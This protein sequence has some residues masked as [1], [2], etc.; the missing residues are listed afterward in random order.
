ME[1]AAAGGSSKNAEVKQLLEQVASFRAQLKFAPFQSAVKMKA[2][3]T[4][5]QRT[6]SAAM[7]PGELHQAM[8]AH[9][10]VA[11][12]TQMMQFMGGDASMMRYGMMGMMDGMNGHAR[13]RSEA[14]THRRKSCPI[15]AY[16]RG[17]DHEVA[18]SGVR[19]STGS[20]RF[21][22]SAAA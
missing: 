15:R 9:I 8:M 7:I 17:G 18:L 12:M 6:K 3:L 20:G 4:D 10:T 22:S 21:S 14:M 16:C 5:S 11:V 13:C 19:R 2:T 1:G